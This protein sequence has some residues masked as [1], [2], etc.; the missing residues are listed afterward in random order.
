MTISVGVSPSLSYPL[1]FSRSILAYV[2][3]GDGSRL[4]NGRPPGRVWVEKKEET[5]VSRMGF[6]SWIAAQ[7]LPR[8]RGQ[9]GR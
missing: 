6:V 2:Y 4:Y 5:A 1:F 8:Y 9:A 7:I 3:S